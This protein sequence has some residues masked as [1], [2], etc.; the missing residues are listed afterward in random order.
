MF[1]QGSRAGV[2]ACLLMGT[3]LQWGA[4]D[5]AH[6]ADGAIL[7]NQQKAQTGSVTTGD[8]A[9]FPVTLSQPGSYVLSG[10]LTVPDQN[11]TAI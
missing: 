10:N 5:A 2:L 4:G 8:T 3:A 6:A 11:T 1:K 9:G 7:I